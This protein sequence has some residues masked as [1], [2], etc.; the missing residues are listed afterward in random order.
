M[1]TETKGERRRL[2]TSRKIW[3]LLI[4]L[5]FVVVAA[6]ILYQSHVNPR[7]VDFKV[8]G[9]GWHGPVPRLGNNGSVA[10]IYGV[11][12]T[13]KAVGGDAHDV[14]VSWEGGP[15]SVPQ[16]VGTMQEDVHYTVLL[17]SYGGYSSRREEIGYPVEIRITSQEKGTKEIKFYI[18]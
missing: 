13:F 5:L 9:A 1:A 16:P 4:L 10:I 6:V 12:V 14:V 3:I 11:S 18:P 7:S 17:F 8:I 2:K 15:G